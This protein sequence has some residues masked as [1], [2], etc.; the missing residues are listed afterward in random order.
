MFDPV[1]PLPGQEVPAGGVKAGVSRDLLNVQLAVV[2][3]NVDIVDENYDEI[4]DID[5][6]NIVILLKTMMR[7]LILM[8]RIL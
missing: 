3:V 8:K 7:I 4:I 6:N 1:S 5:E 2:K